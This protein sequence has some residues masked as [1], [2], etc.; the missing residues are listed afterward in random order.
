MEE[1]IKQIQALQNEIKGVKESIAKGVPTETLAADIET[2]K[3]KQALLDE[4]VRKR[5][6]SMSGLE[7]EKEKFIIPRAIIGCQYN[8]WFDSKGNECK[9]ENSFEFKVMKEYGDA[10]AKDVHST[11][12]GGAYSIPPQAI[13]TYI[14][15]LYSK[16][17]LVEAGAQLLTNLTGSPIYIPRQSGSTNAY[18]VGEG[19]EITESKISDEQIQMTPHEVAALVVINNKLLK[20]SASN[21]SLENLIMNDITRQIKRAIDLKGLRGDGQNNVPVGLENTAPGLG[22][23]VLGANGGYFEFDTMIDMEGVVEDADA[24]D[25]KLA[26]IT[27]GK[28]IR[29]L[30]KQKIAQ[31]TGDAGG[32]PL[33]WPM[34]KQNV[35]DSLGYPFYTTTQIPSNLVKGESGAICTE[36][37]FGNWEDFLIGQWGGMD[38][39]VSDSAGSAFEK[40]QIKIRAIQ[41][42]DFAIRHPESFC[43][44]SDAKTV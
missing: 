5:A 42:V 24:L 28:L 26:L 12:D 11:T 36:A 2:I 8:K 23:L 35:Q 13:M 33:V 29:R 39:A 27:N 17:V 7:D 10:V 30:K 43:V 16:T 14:E 20:L 31:F 37:F 9:A 40:N 15:K 3:A 44:C 1:L 38:I 34:N 32:Q 22:T 6:T 25:G 41:M 21:P 19:S 18:W 4:Q